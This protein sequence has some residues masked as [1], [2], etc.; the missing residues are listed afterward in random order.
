MT[1]LVSLLLLPGHPDA[2]E[3]DCQAHV[4]NG[5]DDEGNQQGAEEDWRHQDGS[6]DYS[7]THQ[8]KQDGAI[9]DVDFQKLVPFCQI[10]K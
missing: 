2:V 3:D 8:K 4:E 1:E 10:S 5:E 6:C 9:S 7:R